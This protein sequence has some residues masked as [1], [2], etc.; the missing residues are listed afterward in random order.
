MYNKTTSVEFIT[1]CVV[2]GQSKGI[3]KLSESDL[4]KRAI[5]VVG[6]HSTDPDIT[7]VVTAMDVLIQGVMKCQSA[8]MLTLHDASVVFNS[9]KWIQEHIDTFQDAAPSDS[10]VVDAVQMPTPEVISDLTTVPP[11]D[12]DSDSEF[13]LNDLSEPMP[14]FL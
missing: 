1:K 4:M 5:D 12:S 9:I 2:F 14:I 7:T 8:G 13:D 3:F 11:D 10:A 6:G